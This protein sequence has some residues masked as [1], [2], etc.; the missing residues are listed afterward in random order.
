MSTYK[1]CVLVGHVI[2]MVSWT[3]RSQ[4]SIC[5]TLNGAKPTGRKPGVYW[6]PKV[7]PL[8][9]AAVQTKV[10]CRTLLFDC[11]LLSIMGRIGDAYSR[12]WGLLWASAFCPSGLSNSREKCSKQFKCFPEDTTSG[13]R[14]NSTRYVCCPDDMATA[15]TQQ[16]SCSQWGLP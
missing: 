11:W 5:A 4:S 9:R 6:S 13:C 14:H 10:R 7:R 15:S 2:R 1:A 8:V 3:A 12:Q 16:L